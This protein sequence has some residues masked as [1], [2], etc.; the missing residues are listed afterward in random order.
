MSISLATKGIIG[1]YSGG[2][3]GGLPYPLGVEDLEVDSDGTEGPFLDVAT[4][5]FAAT[6]SPI[7]ASEIVPSTVK[8]EGMARIKPQF[9]VFPGPNN[10]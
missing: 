9:N 4:D 5:E 8:A 2:G 10:L 1:G 6:P 3:G 7:D